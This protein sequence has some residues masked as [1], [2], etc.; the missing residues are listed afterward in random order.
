MDEVKIHAVW[1]MK[2]FAFM[3]RLRHAMYLQQLV[4]HTFFIEHFCKYFDFL[5]QLY[6]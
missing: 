5:I 6:T 4:V 3:F 2:Y 1:W